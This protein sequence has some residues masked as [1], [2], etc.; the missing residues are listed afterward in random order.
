MA[1]NGWPEGAHDHPLYGALRKLN[2]SCMLNCSREQREI[3]GK[4][5]DAMVSSF[6]EP[7]IERGMLQGGLLG[8][9]ER[10]GEEMN[11]LD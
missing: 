10:M 1:V 5:F 3:I 7:S 6:S 2:E 8:M 11:K 9:I 4:S